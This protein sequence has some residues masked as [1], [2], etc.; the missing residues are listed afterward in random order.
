[1]DFGPPVKKPLRTI[2]EVPESDGGAAPAPAFDLSTLQAPQ[3]PQRRAL[4][5]IS[6]PVQAGITGYAGI[7]V[8]L[9]AL[10]LFN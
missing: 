7:F 1:L 9:L 6:A 3:T 5:G 8:P 4:S 10:M 2:P